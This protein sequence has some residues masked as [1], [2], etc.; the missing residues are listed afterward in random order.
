MTS[1][2]ILVVDDEPSVRYTLTQILEE[3]GFE[4]RAAPDVAS[5]LALVDEVDLILTD[6]VMPGADGV[7]L[8]EAIQAQ[9]LRPPVI[10]L[11][12]R[13][14]EREAVRAIKAGA[15]DYLP[16]PFEL[17]ELLAAINRA[18]EVAGLRQD[19]ALRR[20]ERAMDSAIITRS[21]AY[22]RA[23]T[24][25]IKLASLPVPIL[26]T[27]ESGS[28]KELLSGALHFGG[29]RSSGPCVRFNCA[30]LNDELASAELF[31][32]EK[33]AFTGAHT[34]RM[35]YLRQAHQGTLILDEVA[36]LSAPTQA[37]LLRFLQL[38]EVQPVGSSAPPIK[39]DVRV[40]AMTH[41]DLAERVAQGQ[42][43]ED[44]YYRL[45]VLEVRVPPLRER[46]EDIIPLA[47]HF[48]RRQA[49]RFG[50][51]PAPLE[52][53]LLDRFMAYAWP[54]NVRELEHAVTRALLVPDQDPLRAQP[55][56][57][58]ASADL[59]DGSYRAQLAQ[60]ERQILMRAMAAA[61]GNQS[62]AARRLEISRT[63]LIDKLKRLGL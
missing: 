45:C 56:E 13:G 40:V 11:T 41:E 8:I 9:A 42:F 49:Q 55:L 58:G 19:A 4:V 50:M 30:T 53:A 33:G 61:N 20:V 62:E 51:T 18:L 37:K 32:H 12:A 21:A 35:G 26:I 5:A 43:R 54:G 22:H 7:A 1:S 36:E 14:S 59:A 47:Q 29:A 27:G 25:A 52:R 39:V 34:A 17:D 10:V 60:C 24:L 3:E 16:K 46:P 28:G 23:L 63:T 2:K 38:Q 48:A 44:L 31:G 15:Y 6:L 57:Q